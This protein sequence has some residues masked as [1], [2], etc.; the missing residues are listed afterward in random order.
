MVCILKIKS[1]LHYWGWFL[2]RADNLTQTRWVQ[3]RLSHAWYVHTRRIFIYIWCSHR[4]KIFWHIYFITSIQK[5]DWWSCMVFEPFRI[6]IT[7]KC[8]KSAGE[9]VILVIVGKKLESTNIWFWWYRLLY[10][11]TLRTDR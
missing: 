3:Q 11:I 10:L 6:F 2:L 5:L 7:M 8:R 9:T 4:L 1:I